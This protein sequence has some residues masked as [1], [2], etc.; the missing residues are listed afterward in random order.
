VIGAEPENTVVD[1]T[2]PSALYDVAKAVSVSVI[3][4]SAGEPDA[5]NPH[6]RFDERVV[7]TESGS[8]SSGRPPELPGHRSTLLTAEERAG[9]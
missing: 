3:V 6:V 4:T 1:R 7:E 8:A 9:L 2:F 5:G